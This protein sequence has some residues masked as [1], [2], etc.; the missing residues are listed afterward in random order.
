MRKIT[1]LTTILCSLLIMTGSTKAAI[2]TISTT[3]KIDDNNLQSGGET[4]TTSKSYKTI[5]KPAPKK[6]PEIK[7]DPDT[8]ISDDN[9]LTPEKGPEIKIEPNV[10]ITNEGLISTASNQLEKKDNT[11][12]KNA[13]DETITHKKSATPNNRPIPGVGPEIKIDPDTNTDISSDDMVV[14][15]TTRNSETEN[16]ET[17]EIK[18]IEPQIPYL[19]TYPPFL[20]DEISNPDNGNNEISNQQYNNIDNDNE[21][22]NKDNYNNDYTNV[23]QFLYKK[24][25]EHFSFL[26]ATK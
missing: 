1:I 8:Y 19:P 4:K 23:L 20:W 12:N 24:I 2:S 7:I 15:K 25:L 22:K 5:N 9:S 21:E 6:G 16:S 14:T 11:E 26:T 10:I 18:V 3:V 13:L 17:E